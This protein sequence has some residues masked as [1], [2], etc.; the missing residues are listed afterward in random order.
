[1]IFDQNDKVRPRTTKQPRLTAIVQ[2]RRFSLFGH[3]AR[4]S[5]E[6]DAKKILTASAGRTGGDHQDALVLCGWRLSRKT[7]NPI[8]S[9]W[10]RQSTWLRIVHSGD[11]CL[12]LLLR[13]LTG[14]YHNWRRRLYSF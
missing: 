3:T 5:D 9:P 11:W 12:R 14:A 13:T 6:T 8:T 1:L 10:M 7:W 4:I 2:A